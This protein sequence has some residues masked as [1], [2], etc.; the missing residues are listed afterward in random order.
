MFASPAKVHTR[1][2]R[3]SAARGVSS[4]TSATPYLLGK[5]GDA[6]EHPVIPDHEETSLREGGGLSWDF[7]KIAVLLAK[8]ASCPE[9]PWLSA[10]S[11]SGVIQ[12]K[13]VVGHANDPLEHEADRIADRV[14]GMPDPWPSIGSTRSQVSRK[15]DACEKKD[16]EL[17]RNAAGLSDPIV[18][19]APQISNDAL[20]SGSQSLEPATRAF[21]ERRFGYDFSRVRVHNDYRATES[22]KAINALAYTVGQDIVFGLGRYAPGTAAGRHLIAHELVHVVQQGKQGAPEGERKLN[23]MAGRHEPNVERGSAEPLGPLQLQAPSMVSSPFIQRTKICSK[24]LEAPGLGLL[25]NH[26]YIDDTGMDNCMGNSM[27]GNYAVQTLFNG[28]FLKGC[29]IKTRT[30]TDPQTYTPNVKQCDPAPGVTDLSKCL[31]DAYTRYSDPS[32]YQNFPVENGPNSNTF[33]ATLANSCCADGSS[34]G[35]GWVPGWNHA[36]ATP[37]VLVAGGPAPAP[38]MSPPSPPPPGQG[39]SNNAGSG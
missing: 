29:A 7:T 17:Q 20:H 37:C 10:H 31:S 23:E 3:S 4:K 15:C 38:G 12:P 27:P 30:S 32:V 21:F 22:A 34:S 19:E 9:A 39:A 11:I 33:A 5:P 14:M 2:A 16:N 26:S 24:R 8:R 25:F 1:N 28:N 36:P 18:G 13:L 35:L 6:S